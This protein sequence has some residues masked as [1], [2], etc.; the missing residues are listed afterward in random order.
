MPLTPG[1]HV[2]AAGFAAEDAAELSFEEGDLLTVVPSDAPEG[3]CLATTKSTGRT[4]LA[5][6]DFLDPVTAARVLAAF[7]AEQPGELSVAARDEV[8][9]VDGASGAEGWV[10]V[11]KGREKGMVPAAYVEAAAPPP[12]PPPKTASSGAGGGAAATA[13][14]ATSPR[15][16]AMLRCRFDA[17]TAAEMSAEA[18][19]VVYITDESRVDEG[20]VEVARDGD[21]AARGLV[22]ADY[23]A[24]SELC[25]VLASFEAQDAAVEMSVSAGAEVWLLPVQATNGWCQAQLR[26]GSR[27]GLV[28]RDF[29]QRA[30]GGDAPDADADA[31]GAAATAAAADAARVREQIVAKKVAGISAGEWDLLVKAGL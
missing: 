20:W 16:P 14:A 13:A 10:M 26:D 11:M 7:D 27:R 17:E 23:L 30:G 18:G 21:G 15:A 28:P 19:E 31:D 1:L 2:A 8:V 25:E 9:L 4:G 29:L 24:R 22:P 3:W 5:P 12:P 6:S